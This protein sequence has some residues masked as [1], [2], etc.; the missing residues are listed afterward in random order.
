MKN[1]HVQKIGVIALGIAI[2]VVLGYFLQ[3]PQGPER[4]I[5]NENE[6]MTFDSRSGN[7][8]ANFSD[9]ENEQVIIYE[10]GDKIAT[11]SEEQL[12]LSDDNYALETLAWSD[13]DQL[14]LGSKL[15]IKL[16]KVHTYNPSTDV[17][18]VFDVSELNMTSDEYALN[19]ATKMIVYSDY[20]FAFETRDDEDLS[21]T[22][23]KLYVYNLESK[24]EEVI[25]TSH[26]R[27][28]FQPEWV[29]DGAVE[30]DD[31]ETG[32]RV[33]VTLE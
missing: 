29:N 33:E 22:P 25:A 30:Y 15:G 11:L 16:M 7:Y 12:E 21:D 31:P 10:S 1:K 23:N 24:E 32:E 26:A 19:P 6:N 14:W 8:G 13:A 9:I 4:Q 20:N 3:T 2:L 27:H 17:L 28:R 5:D 18:E